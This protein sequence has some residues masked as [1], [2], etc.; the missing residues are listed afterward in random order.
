MKIDAWD[1]KIL[2]NLYKN[3]RATLSELSKGV[4]LPKENIHYRLKRFE[5]ENFINYI[6][7]VNLSKM[8]FNYFL[9]RIKIDPISK[10]YSK[11]V[12]NLIKNKRVLWLSEDKIMQAEEFNLTMIMI[13]NDFSKID[14]YLTTLNDTKV[15]EN[16]ELYLSRTLG[17]TYKDIYSD[18]KLFNCFLKV[19]AHRFEKIT[20]NIDEKLVMNLLENSRIS[21]KDLGLKLRLAPL[22]IKNRIKKLVEKN[23][24]NNF[25][26][27]LNLSKLDDKFIALFYS[28]ETMNVSQNVRKITSKYFS[29]VM[30]IS[31]F[32]SKTR[33]LFG[34]VKNED[35][36]LKAMS[37]LNKFKG[38]KLI[39]VSENTKILKNKVF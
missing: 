38:A 16:F 13:Y 22:T 35:S 12:K 11:F 8:G 25:M 18:E 28:A 14:D 5:K 10:E 30:T 2:T 34:R 33:I 6:P 32:F 39:S 15:I 19:G 27:S 36:F 24:I 1:K 31:T 23:V 37:E 17:F 26:V 20:D 4:G 3:S 29:E 7:Y 21:L 9:I